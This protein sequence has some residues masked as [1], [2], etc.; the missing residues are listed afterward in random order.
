MT[1]HGTD[2]HRA[3]ER[4]PAAIGPGLHLF[5]GSSW[6]LSYYLYLP[7]QSVQRD[8]VLVSVHGVSRN[9]L[10]HVELLRGFADRNGFALVAPLFTAG[11]FRDYQRLGRRGRGPRADLA[12]IRVLN[13]IAMETGLDTGKVDMFGFSGGAQFVHRF[14]YAHSQ[15]VRSLILGSAGWYTM[16]DRSLPYPYGTAD[17]RGLDAVRFNLAAAARL[18]TLVVVGGEDDKEDDEELNCSRPVLQSQGRHRLERARTWTAAMNVLAR[19]QGLPDPAELVVLPGVGH[20]FRQAVEDGALAHRL[21]E[22]CSRAAPLSEPR[23]VA[24]RSIVSTYNGGPF[25]VCE[26]VQ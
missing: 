24:R 23:V 4:R 22:H 20:S 3:Q 25:G 16:P 13:E 17:A 7:R 14:A 21:F 19:Q 5:K 15:R 26:T 2:Q 18:P 9:A 12:L 11:T 10:E 6:S 8:R 1:I